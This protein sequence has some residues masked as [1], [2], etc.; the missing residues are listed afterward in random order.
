[1]KKL[2]KNLL[3]DYSYPAKATSDYLKLKKIPYDVTKVKN[4]HWVKA[5]V[6]IPNYITKGNWYINGKYTQQELENNNYDMSFDVHPHSLGSFCIGNPEDKSFYTVSYE[7]Y[8]HFDLEHVMP[9]NPKNNLHIVFFTNYIEEEEIFLS[10][11]DLLF[12]FFQKNH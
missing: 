2:R 6:T 9:F 10:G 1:M 5:L 4:G 7:D 12:D 3:K 11:N 8:W